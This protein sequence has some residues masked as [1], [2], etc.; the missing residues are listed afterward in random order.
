MVRDKENLNRWNRER[1]HQRKTEL[2]YREKR[3]KSALK[4]YHSHVKECAKRRREYFL[5]NIEKYRK[6]RR[7]W[8]YSTPAGIYACVKE[9][10]KNNGRGH[11]LSIT[12]EEFIAWHNSQEKICS[13]CKRTHEECQLDIL[14]RKVNRLTIDRIDNSR[15]YEKGNLALACY[16]CNAIKNNYF[17]PD[18]MLKIGRIIHDKNS[19]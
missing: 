3:K 18:E 2:I 11:K 13:Y 1:Y 10:C 15:G 19:K 9:G 14:N 8:R 5:K 4:Y 12:K 17:T 16:R 7:E 6:Y